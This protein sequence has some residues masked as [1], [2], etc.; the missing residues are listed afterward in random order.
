MMFVLMGSLV[1]GRSVGYY[2]SSNVIFFL[3]M[4]YGVGINLLRCADARRQLVHLHIL[5]V[6]A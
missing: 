3:V 6:C 5:A 2:F 4:L 1:V